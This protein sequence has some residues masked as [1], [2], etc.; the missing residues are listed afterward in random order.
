MGKGRRGRRQAAGWSFEYAGMRCVIPAVYRFPGGVVFDILS[1]ADKAELAE[2]I[3]RCES[4]E[5]KL[6]PSERRCAEQENPF[7]AVSIREIWLNDTQRLGDISYSHAASVPW[8]RQ[9]EAFK[10][11]RRAY[12]RYIGKTQPFAC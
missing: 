4:A 1:F 6:T 10:P 11:L 2:Y 5:E 7:K 9:Y 3:S 12:R 8:A